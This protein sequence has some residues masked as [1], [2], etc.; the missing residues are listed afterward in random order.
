MPHTLRRAAE[1]LVSVKI[2]SFTYP[3]IGVLMK[4]GQVKHVVQCQHP[5]GSLCKIHGWIDVIL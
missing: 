2:N 3:D 1:V 5:R 4:F